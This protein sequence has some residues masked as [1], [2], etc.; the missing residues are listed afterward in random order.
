MLFLIVESAK[1]VR[2]LTQV[3]ETNEVNVIR[4]IVTGIQIALLSM[5][6]EFATTKVIIQ[7]GSTLLRV[8]LDQDPILRACRMIGRHQ[9]V[10]CLIA[11]RI[12]LDLIGLRVQ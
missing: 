7:R 2:I 11:I 8:R 3:Q 4:P 12:M 5:L 9:K 10:Q 6:I 1:N